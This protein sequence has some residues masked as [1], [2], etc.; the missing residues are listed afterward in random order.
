[1]LSKRI[2]KDTSYSSKEKIYQKRTLNSEH[3]RYKFKDTHIHMKK[4]TK[5]QNTHCTS[6]NNCGKFQYPTLIN[7]HFMKTYTKQKH[8]GTQRSNGLNGF[9]R[10]L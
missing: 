8:I 9:N 10:H 6:H 2:R 1:M 5:S 4:F 7:G 3:L